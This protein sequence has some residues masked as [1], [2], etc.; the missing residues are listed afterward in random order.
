MPLALSTAGPV[1]HKEC[2]FISVKQQM[3]GSNTNLIFFNRA[4]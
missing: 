2:T 3:D 4:G 1:D